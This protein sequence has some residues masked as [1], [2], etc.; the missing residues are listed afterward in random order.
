MSEATLEQIRDGWNAAAEQDAM[1][2]IL[3]TGRAWDPDEFFATGRAEIQGCFEHLDGLG[4]RGEKRERALDF[5]CGVGRLTNGL[6]DHYKWVT[7]VDIAPEMCAK[8]R[9]HP[10]IHY[11]CDA[12]L[13]RFDAGTFDLIYSNLVLQHMPQPIAYDYIAQFIRIL[14]PDGLAV[15]EIPEGPEYRHPEDHLSMY[16]SDRAT[17]EQVVKDAGGMVVDVDIVKCEAGAWIPYRYA[18]KRCSRS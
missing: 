6:A 16:A 7:G 4:L 14:H 3:T 10:R 9:A 8:A 1:G 5:G 2:N 15:F 13:D 12:S 17:I 11:Y 18:A